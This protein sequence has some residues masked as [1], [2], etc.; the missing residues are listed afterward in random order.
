MI[1]DSIYLHFS[2]HTI[3]LFQSLR[4]ENVIKKQN[5]KIFLQ[6]TLYMYAVWKSQTK[7]V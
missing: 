7:I 4:F 1:F 2:I 5:W 6:S 3:I